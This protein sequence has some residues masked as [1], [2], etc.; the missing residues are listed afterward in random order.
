MLR[1]RRAE[2]SMYSRA[3]S[4]SAGCR[5]YGDASR[6][7]CRTICSVS[8]GTAESAMQEPCRW[9]VP[10]GWAFLL[11]GVHCMCAGGVHRAGSRLTRSVCLVLAPQ[12]FVNFSRWRAARRSRRRVRRG[13]R[14]GGL[15]GVSM[16]CVELRCLDRTSQF[17][18]V[19]STPGG[20]LGRG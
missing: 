20:L 16:T 12:V 8:R 18:T 15:A 14:G 17:S 19:F 7:P 5:Q 2:L 6:G 11:C 4:G 9:R 1:W 13:E 3:S 10:A